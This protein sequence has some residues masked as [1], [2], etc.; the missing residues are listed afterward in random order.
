LEHVAYAAWLKGFSRKEAISRGREALDIVGLSDRAAI[1][2]TRLS[3]GQQRRVGLAAALVHNATIL[4]LDEP[5]VGLDPAERKRLRDYLNSLRA[6]HD[7]VISTHQ[8]D[9][10]DLLAD[11]VA[12]MTQGLIICCTPT[13]DFLALA[14][15]A[16]TDAGRAELAYARL[17]GEAE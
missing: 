4:L 5:A 10:L 13:R 2:T 15:D 1:Q 12:V 14:S 8:V 16:V 11:H 9:D 17:L 7:I 6:T 3:G